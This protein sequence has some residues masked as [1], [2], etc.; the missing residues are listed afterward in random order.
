MKKRKILYLFPLAALILSGCTLQEGLASAKKFVGNYMYFPLRNFAASLFGKATVDPNAKKDEKQGEDQKPSGDDQTPSGEDTPVVPGVKHA[1]TEADPFDGDDAMLVANS[2]EA[3]K[4][5]DDSYFIK[6]KVTEIT[7]AYDPQYGSY[8]FKIEGGFLAYQLKYGKNQE[9]FAEGDIAVDD[10]VTFYAQIQLYGSENPTAET[11]GGYVV[12]I[13]KPAI[14]DTLVSLAIAGNPQTSYL[15][16]DEYNR[17]GLSAVATYEKAGE[18]DVTKNAKWSI[19]KAVAAVGDESITI[20]AEYG[21]MKKELVVAVKVADS[22]TVQH[23]GTL[24]DPYTG[25]DAAIIASGLEHNTPT[26]QSYYIQGAVESITEYS[27]QY[28]NFTF[29]I[30]GG[31]LCYRLKKGSSKANFA[32]DDLKVGDTVLVYA[33]IMRFYE[34]NETKDGYVAKINGVDQDSTTP[35]QPTERVELPYTGNI[36]NKELPS[37]WTGTGQGFG[38]NYYAL[39]A[40]GAYVQAVAFF[41]AVNK[42]EVSVTGIC[43]GTDNDS[44][45]TVYGLDDKGEAISGASATYTPDKA[46]ASNDAAVDNAATEKTVE[47]NGEGI[48]GVKIE[49]TNKGHNYVMKQIK[50]AAPT[51][52]AKVLQSISLTG[53]TKTSYLVGESLDLTG[54]VVTG[55]YLTGEEASEEEIKT[56]YTVSQEGAFTSQDVPGKEITVTYQGE[57]AKFSVTVAEPV[58]T[59]VSVTISGTATKTNYIVGESYSADGLVIKANYSDNSFIDITNSEELELALSKTTAV[60]GDTEFTVTATYKEVSSQP[61]PVSVTVSEPVAEKGTLENPYTVAEVIETFSSLGNNAWSDEM[62]HVIGEVKEYAG[63]AK[64]HG[65]TLT[66]GE[67][68]LI[69]YKSELPATGERACVGDQVIFYGWIENF[70]GNTLEMTSYNSPHDALPTLASIVSRGTSTISLGSTSSEHATVTFNA[71]ATNASSYSFSVAVDQGHTLVSVMFAG[72]E[73][74][75]ENGVYTVTVLGNSVIVVQTVEEGGNVPITVSKTAEELKTEHNWTACSGGGDKGDAKFSSFAFDEVITISF[76]GSAST[77]TAT[78]WTSG[79]EIRIYG[80]KGTT[81]ASITFTAAT[82]YTI[83]SVTMTF[84]TSGTGASFPLTSGEA[85]N[86][87]DSTVTYLLTAGANNNAQLKMTAFTVV[88][89][90]N[91]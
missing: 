71:T 43:N 48:T 9:K 27:S 49:L 56:G 11:K 13:E 63:A 38:S 47:I 32:E 72:E 6:G 40:N 53:P 45:V 59:L 62:V 44:T 78:Y 87:N 75:G 2:L 88:Y 7:K 55:H 61:Y 19:S 25:A 15:A 41:E 86:V 46:S 81:D 39:K 74:D 66:D 28:G 18:K 79:S 29:T 83:K 12:Q 4:Y 77:N 17:N 5:T 64:N 54:L 89:V 20:S 52:P 85:A 60:L 1:G 51:A 34:K 65:Y 36:S 80:N 73:V 14:D 82:G 37:G 24:E 31:F 70:N 30:D 90:A 91:N 33:Q 16:G 42:L 26:E 69:V 67:N 84:T 50:L 22:S 58:A 3:G 23:Q 21:G 10:V 8:T 57:T 68:D 35:P 76:T